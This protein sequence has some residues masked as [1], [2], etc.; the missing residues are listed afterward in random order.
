MKVDKSQWITRPICELFNLQMGKTPSRKELHLWEGGD[1]P[2]VSISDMNS[3]NIYETKEMLPM[4]TIKSCN[5]PIV[6]SNTV[7][8]SFKLTI[9]KVSILG[10][11]AVHNEAI[12]SIFPF[13]L[14]VF[15]P[16]FVHYSFFTLLLFGSS[17]FLVTLRL[18]VSILCKRCFFYIMI[19]NLHIIDRTPERRSSPCSN[20]FCF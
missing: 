14:S 17:R 3:K 12:I 4:S 11:D 10:I 19:K 9:G 18:F 6:P 13:V 7:I 2:W 20:E 8:M 5:V 1:V 16:S 15:S